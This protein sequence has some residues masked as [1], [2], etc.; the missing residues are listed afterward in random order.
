MARL[1]LHT[2]LLYFLIFANEVLSLASVMVRDLE[3]DDALLPERH[4]RA[5][6]RINE[7]G[8]RDVRG[9]LQYDHKLHYLDGEYDQSSLLNLTD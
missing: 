8:A 5:A 6:K 1:L 2:F 9:C 4:M 3:P 7:L